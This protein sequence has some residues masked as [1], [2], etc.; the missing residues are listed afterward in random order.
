MVPNPDFHP[1]GDYAL[2]DD[3]TLHTGAPERAARLTF[4]NI[5]IYDPLLFEGVAPNTRLKLSV[6]FARAIAAQRAIG[7]RFDGRWHNLGTPSQLAGLDAQLRG[8]L[9]APDPSR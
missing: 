2:A 6:L 7:E 1:R 5:G 4:G 9:P 3:G 8:G